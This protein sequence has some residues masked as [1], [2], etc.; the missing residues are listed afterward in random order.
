MA[1][2]EQGEAF[3][4]EYMKK[5]LVK[6]GVVPDLAEAEKWLA[7]HSPEEIVAYL[8]TKRYQRIDTAPPGQYSYGAISSSV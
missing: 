7:A 5:L 3:A 8:Q 6:D 1:E 4:H 2:P